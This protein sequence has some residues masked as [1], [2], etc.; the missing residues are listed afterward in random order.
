MLRPIIA[1]VFLWLAFP[2]PASALQNV[3]S[4][5]FAISSPDSAN[6]AG[7][8]FDGGLIT[9][10][11]TATATINA[12]SGAEWIGQ[13]FGAGNSHAIIQITIEQLSAATA[14]NSV[15]V[16]YGDC[17][18][19]TVLGT[20]SVTK[21][22]GLNTIDFSSVGAHRC[23]SLLANANA[24]GNER[25]QVTRITMSVASGGSPSPKFQAYRSVDFN[26]TTGSFFVV[27]FDAQWYDTNA[28]YDPAT[29]RFQPSVAGYYAIC[30]QVMIK[31]TITGNVHVEVTKN[32][33]VSGGFV[34]PWWA[35]AE[36]LFGYCIDIPMNGTSDFLD[37]RVKVVS[38]S[39]VQIDGERSWF[40]GHFIGT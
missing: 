29:Y 18:T 2:S 22:A 32:A 16:R 5:A 9:N 12:Q 10:W 27:P 37:V 33:D 31:G 23:W 15:K 34:K 28:N 26:V 6:P 20:Y 39:N 14:I 21:D 19:W 30:A 11:A 40:I 24:G 13:D 7:N 36:G 8:A 3:V 35:P 1:A 38:G 25:W 17:S 4:S